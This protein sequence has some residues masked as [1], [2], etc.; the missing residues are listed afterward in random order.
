MLVLLVLSVHQVQAVLQVQQALQEIVK[1]PVQLEAQALQVHQ[2]Q[3][4]HRD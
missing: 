3:Q 1:H 2:V 4:V